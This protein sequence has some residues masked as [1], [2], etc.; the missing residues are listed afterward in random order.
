M[1]EASLY[2]AYR[3]ISTNMYLT[4]GFLARVFINRQSLEVE[5]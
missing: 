3:Y 1:F 4:N 5:T 2:L